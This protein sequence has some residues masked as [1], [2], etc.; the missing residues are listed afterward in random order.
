MSII[1]TWHPIYVFSDMKGVYPCQNWPVK[2][3]ED[4]YI[5]VTKKTQ[6]SWKF[7]E[8]NKKIKLYTT[9]SRLKIIS[10]LFLLQN[11]TY[12]STDIELILQKKINMKLKNT[13]CTK[14]DLNIFITVQW[15][16]TCHEAIRKLKRT[17]FNKL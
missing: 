13:D 6:M 16:T 14:D 12:T 8:T 15:R 5:A 3:T 4:T 7:R 2:V 1:V 10:I 9:I 11:K 17:Q